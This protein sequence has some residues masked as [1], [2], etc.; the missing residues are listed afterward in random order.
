MVTK[1][2]ISTQQD[3]DEWNICQTDSGASYAAVIS[4]LL[5]APISPWK[6]QQYPDGHV[7]GVEVSPWHR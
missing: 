7:E 3:G 6:H 1:I 5:T 4:A 2:R